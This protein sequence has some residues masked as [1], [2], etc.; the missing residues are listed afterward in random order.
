MLI[1]GTSI[2]K[3]QKGDFEYQLHQVLSY[4]LNYLV[5]FSFQV[6][7]QEFFYSILFQLFVFQI[8]QKE[9]RDRDSEILK[10]DDKINLLQHEC[11]NLT[12]KIS[13]LEGK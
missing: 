2:V 7:C 3:H 6:L 13:I 11:E 9:I 10:R 12:S 8:A 5:N 4:N 1:V